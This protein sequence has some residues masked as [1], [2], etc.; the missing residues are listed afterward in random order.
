MKFLR[1]PLVHFLLL[2]VAIFAAY[3]IISKHTAERPGEI[4]ITSGKIEN[5]VTTFSRTWQRPPTQEELSGLIRDYVREEVAYREAK[6][7]GLDEDDTIIRRRLRQ[8][9]EFVSDNL[10]SLS[11]PTDGELQAYLKSHPENFTTESTY[12][13]Q[14]VYLNPQK[15]GANLQ[16]DAQQL[17][18]KLQQAGDKADALLLS[19]SFLLNHQFTNVSETELKKVF[20]ERFAN[21][22]SVLKLGLWKG[23]IE[24]GYGA[25]LV[26][27]SNRS[28]GRTALLEEVRDQVR[29]EWA[30]AKRVETSEKFYQALLQRYE[31]TIQPLQEKQVA[32]LRR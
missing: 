25:H 13:F 6:A 15:H 32:K 19:D 7:M 5:M 14:Q 22:I 1:E 12:T 30:N 4:V 26:F 29:R 18:V 31:V 17:L 16:K 20:G 2:G 8:K 23:P 27:L 21:E 3:N 9:L 28:P 11:E 24:S 10:A